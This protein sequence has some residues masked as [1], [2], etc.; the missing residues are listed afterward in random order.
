M[1]KGYLHAFTN[2]SQNII[3]ASFLIIALSCIGLWLI[4]DTYTDLDLL[5]QIGLVVFVITI[6]SLI[7]ST[8]VAGLIN[9]PISH[10]ANAVYHLAPNNSSVPAPSLEKIPL[11]RE[12]TTNLI[13]QI[14]DLAGNAKS[15]SP[16]NAPS[17]PVLDLIK[18]PIIGVDSSGNIKLI[19][20]SARDV[21]GKNIDPIN[22]KF[23]E[24]FNIDESGNG[25]SAWISET[26]SKQLT[27][28]KSFNRVGLASK[29][30]GD[31]KYYDLSI[32]F[33]RHSASGTDTLYCFFDQID[34]YNQ[35]DDSFGFIALAVHELRTP[36]TVLR[37]YAEVLED[38]SKKDENLYG[39]VKRIRAS[40]DS[41]SFFVTNILN[42]ARVDQ[43]ELKLGL[44]EANW[45][46][47]V[48][49]VIDETKI[50]AEIFDKEI[51]FTFDNDIPTVGVDPITIAE[52][53]VN[54]I[55]NAIKYSASDTSPIEISCQMNSEGMVATTVKDSGEGIPAS[56]MPHIF[57]KFSRNH[58]NKV[59]VAGTGLGLYLSK[60]IVNAHGGTI[61][62]RSKEG[63]G[64]EFTFTLHPFKN[65][66]SQNQADQSIIRNSHGWIK[67][68][69]LNRS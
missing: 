16:Q 27:S 42:V 32:N 24:I 37:G 28:S 9:Q 45:P 62:A 26:N 57:E 33:S 25:I 67:N 49:K 10:I 39:Y 43:Q 48:Q 29:I 11:G 19:N 12:L 44:S 60:S 20:S 5:L 3:F 53:V 55:D 13:R 68:H 2:K 59:R 21:A 61:T 58:H 56:V 18:M 38:E 31:Y 52:V 36:L 34:K 64:S 7:I 41:L 66:A 15:I 51:K 4:I 35:E 54:L 14:Y 69:N 17:E 50:R 46:D 1:N 30:S 23:T 8:F 47:L 65:V 40:L 22:K 63:E 6:L